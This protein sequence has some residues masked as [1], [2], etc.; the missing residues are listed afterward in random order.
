ME[1]GCS[2]QYL[3]DTTLELFSIGASGE[4]M[5]LDMPDLIR[6]PIGWHLC[7]DGV[8]CQLRYC[9]QLKN[10]CINIRWRAFQFREKHVV[11]WDDGIQF[12]WFWN[13]TKKILWTSTHKGFFMINDH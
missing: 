11:L 10:E 4:N 8:Q 2:C 12:P 3:L 9:G 1:C 7:N 5:P 6:N 13:D